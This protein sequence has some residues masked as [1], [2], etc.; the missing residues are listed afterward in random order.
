MKS[1]L[2]RARDRAYARAGRANVAEDVRAAGPSRVAAFT[3]TGK[4][5][6][7]GT[8]SN[9]R[10]K[11][12]TPPEIVEVCRRVATGAI[13]REVEFGLDPCAEGWS[14]KAP[15]FFT[16]E[17]DGLVQS[18]LGYGDVFVNPPYSDV[19]PWFEKATETVEKAAETGEPTCVVVLSGVDT[20]TVWFKRFTALA[21]QTSLLVPRI[22]YLPPAAVIEHAR[23]LGTKPP[24]GNMRGSMIS[25]FD[26][27][28][29][30]WGVEYGFPAIRVLNWKRLLEGKT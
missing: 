28:R 12:G 18:W 1:T 6:P 21:L 27:E 22:K 25:V 20:S 4:N 24:S 2:Q 14:A 10:D 5:A 9:E 7:R 29:D 26:S 15:G 3:R 23:R 8:R 17:D 16:E 19:T 11:W 30:E 13:G